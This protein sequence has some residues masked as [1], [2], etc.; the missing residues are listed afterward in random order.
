MALQA[1]DGIRAPLVC[2]L[3]WFDVWWFGGRLPMQTLYNNQEF[4][5][6]NPVQPT[7][8]GFVFLARW[9]NGTGYMEPNINLH[10]GKQSTPPPLI[11]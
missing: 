9:A 10:K 4:K 11:F 6:P 3:A 1:N 2:G 7:S 8:E 5:S